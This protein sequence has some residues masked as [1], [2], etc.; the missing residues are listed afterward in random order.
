MATF[1]HRKHSRDFAIAI[2]AGRLPM[3][4]RERIIAVAITLPFCV[5]LLIA[6]SRLVAAQGDIARMKSDYR[7]PPPSAV[8]SQVLVDLGRDLFF[9]PQISASGKTA[10]GSFHFP[11]LGLSGTDARSL[12]D[13][14]KLTSRKS[15]PLIG[16]GHAGKGPFGWDGRNPSLEAQAKSSI[17]T[18]SVSTGGNP[19]RVRGE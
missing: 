10:F 7:R 14:G 8:E 1:G 6:A 16:L 12:N 3:G 13:S 2:S 15:Q 17:A 18:G 4:I 5:L 11:E 19:T 9:D